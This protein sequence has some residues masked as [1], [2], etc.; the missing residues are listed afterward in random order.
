MVRKK[1]KLPAPL[2]VGEETFARDLR[3]YRVDK[4]F[5]REYRFS[6]DR[7][8]R[9]DFAY[10]DQKIAIE[11]EGGTKYGKSRHSRGEGFKA[12]CE[13]YNTA[14]LLGWAVYRFTTDMVTR[15][16]AIDFVRSLL[17]NRS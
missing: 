2:S 15:G 13:K 4:L 17:A 16:E 10:V 1:S 9:F 12:D 6:Q 5:Q 8:W 11:I 7:E 14:A 3:A